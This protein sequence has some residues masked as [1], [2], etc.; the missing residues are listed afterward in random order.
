MFG[1]CPRHCFL[2]LRDACYGS[3]SFT[4]R[5]SPSF[6][7]LTAN[8]V[9]GRKNVVLL[10]QLLLKV[11]SR[12]LFCADKTI[13]RDPEKPCGHAALPLAA[14]FSPLRRFLGHTFRMRRKFTFP[15]AAPARRFGKKQKASFL[16]FQTF[17]YSHGSRKRDAANRCSKKVL[18]PRG[19]KDLSVNS[20]SL[21]YYLGGLLSQLNQ[22]CL[23]SAVL[24]KFFRYI[25]PS[26]R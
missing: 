5:A 18:V 22:R 9:R 10:A 19:Y 17:F 11:T 3:P 6:L 23:L 7:S 14:L 15:S 26:V 13:F 20:N 4:H 25:I 2:P 12:K 24:M 16:L 8:R 1:R 21:T